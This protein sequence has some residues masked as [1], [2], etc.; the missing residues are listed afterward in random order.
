MREFYPS[1]EYDSEQ[2]ERRLKNRRLTWKLWDGRD[3]DDDDDPPPAPAAA[4]LPKPVPLVDGV[5]LIPA[6]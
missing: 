2:E 3:D 6:A 5:A 1:N 4:Q